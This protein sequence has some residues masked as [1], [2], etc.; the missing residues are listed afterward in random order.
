MAERESERSLRCKR[1]NIDT[2]ILCY[3]L[4][5]VF[6]CLFIRIHMPWLLIFPKEADSGR[7]PVL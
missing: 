4:R 2:Q 6:L 5:Y 1:V 7:P 3:L